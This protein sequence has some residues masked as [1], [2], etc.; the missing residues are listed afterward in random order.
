MSTT[1]NG[2]TTTSL[3]TIT[4]KPLTREHMQE[5]ADLFIKTFCD[6]EPI[7]KKLGITYDEYEPFAM[8]LIQK[9]VTDGL[10]LVALENNKIVALTISEDITNP[11]EPDL[12]LYPKMAPIIAIIEQLTTPFV[13][14]KKIKKGKIAHTWISL[15]EKSHTNL[16]LNTKIDLAT[17]N[18]CASKG[19]D[20]T[21]AEFTSQISENIAHHYQTNKKINEVT[22]DTFT[23]KGT[24]P[25][26]GVKGGVTSYI[27]GIKPGVKIDD[28]D[29]C[30]T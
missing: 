26:K 25:F 8:A 30:Y 16:G 22:Y 29:K 19:F 10:G 17:T 3:E 13:S 2:N 9:A 23:Y 24:Q 7:T 15:V 28:L 4:I 18:M 12:A 21:Y 27:L 20:F 5:A 1:N 11:F 6:Y 14:G